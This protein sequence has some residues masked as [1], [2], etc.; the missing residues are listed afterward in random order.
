MLLKQVFLCVCGISFGLLASA[1]VFT[2][3]QPVLCGTLAALGI[4][5]VTRGGAGLGR[6]TAVL[7]LLAAAV[8]LVGIGVVLVK[9]VAERS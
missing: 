5:G 8:I 3:L 7:F 2:V 4:I 1:G 9:R 6:Q